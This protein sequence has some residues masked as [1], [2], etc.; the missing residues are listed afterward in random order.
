MKNNNYY[1][2]PTIVSNLTVG[3]LVYIDLSI[4]RGEDIYDYKMKLTVSFKNET[5]V[6]LITED[7]IP[8]YF[9]LDPFKEYNE[10][11]LSDKWIEYIR[12]NRQEIENSTR[13]FLGWT[14]QVV[15]R[16]VSIR[17]EVYE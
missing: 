13:N 11:Q 14:H 3:D 1:Y 12:E 16:I 4:A 6:E 10:E 5:F 2:F 15:S 7:R 17:K 9:V 8:Y